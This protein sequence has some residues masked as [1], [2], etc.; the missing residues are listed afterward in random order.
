MHVVVMDIRYVLD[1][2]YYYVY[3]ASFTLKNFSVVFPCHPQRTNLMTLLEAS[4][5]PCW[6]L[7]HIM[8]TLCVY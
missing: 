7:C 8:L 4:R 3:A 2:D 5:S 1:Y 6:Q